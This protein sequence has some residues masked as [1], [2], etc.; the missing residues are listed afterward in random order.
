MNAD[1][2]QQIGFETSMWNPHCGYKT[3]IKFHQIPQWDVDIFLRIRHRKY[4]GQY[5]AHRNRVL[6]AV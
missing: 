1:T 5:N 6:P 2:P 4:I 3:K